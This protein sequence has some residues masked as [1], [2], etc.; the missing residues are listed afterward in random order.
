MSEIFERICPYYMMYGMS[1]EE[2]WHGD[3]WCMK[4]Y[5]ESYLLKQEQQNTMLWLQGIYFADA[6][7]ITLANAF[8]K[9]GSPPRKYME[10]PI[11]IFPKTKAEEERDLAD[12]QE[13]LI[14]GLTAWKRMAEAKKQAD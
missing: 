6:F 2:Y 3:P 11:D 4:A 14:A 9:K 8:S 13:K 1:Y 7:G 5:H 12:K 10:K